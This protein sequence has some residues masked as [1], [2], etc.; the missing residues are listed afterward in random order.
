MDNALV[1]TQHA[2]HTIQILLEHY[3][4]LSIHIYSTRKCESFGYFV[5]Q[6]N[7]GKGNTMHE[8]VFTFPYTLL[9]VCLYTMYVYIYSLL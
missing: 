1:C 3:L 5:V 4:V 8:T 9:C 2:T 6:S 7:N